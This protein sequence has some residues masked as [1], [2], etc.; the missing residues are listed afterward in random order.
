MADHALVPVI[1]S[2]VPG[3]LSV[4][5]HVLTLVKLRL[6]A[7]FA[8][9]RI[10]LGLWILGRRREYVLAFVSRPLAPV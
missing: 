4:I 7:A 8:D 6:I 2:Y 1:L 5:R 9:R 10:S 3:A